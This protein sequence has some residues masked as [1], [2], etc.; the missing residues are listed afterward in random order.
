MAAEFFGGCE[1]VVSGF[2]WT[3]NEWE[4]T[5]HVSAEPQIDSKLNA[6]LEPSK[7][8][9]NPSNLLTCCAKVN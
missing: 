9:R 7:Q 2:R 3:L 4:K 6:S 1:S 8:S 5:N